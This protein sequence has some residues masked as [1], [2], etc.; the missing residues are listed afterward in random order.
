MKKEI[1]LDELARM[2]A[3][4]FEDMEGRFKQVDKRFDRLETEVKGIRTDLKEKANLSDFTALERRV[5]MLEARL[6]QVA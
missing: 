3:K 1:T 6:L 4:G 5:N 2:V